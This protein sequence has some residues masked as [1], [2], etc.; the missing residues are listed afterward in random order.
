MKNIY[1]LSFI[2]TVAFCFLVSISLFAQNTG[3]LRGTVSDSLTGEAL[4]FSNV[5]LEGTNYG[6]SADLNGNFIISGIPAGKNYILIVSYLS[7]TKKKI[8]VSVAK[9]Q[10]LQMRVDLSPTTVMLQ[11]V[12]KIGEK[13]ARPNETDL[14]L[15][16]LNIRDIE[17]LPKGIE[18]DILRSLQS[19]PGVQSTGDVSARYYVRGGSSNENLVLL[20]GVSVYNPFHALGLFSIIDPEMINAVEFYRGGFSSEFGGRLSSVLNLV[21]KDGNKNRYSGNAN[22]SFLT[23]KAAFEGPLPGGSFML[24]G[25]KSLFSKTLRRFINYKDAPFDF[26]DLSFKANFNNSSDKSLTKVSVHGFNSLDNLT[27]EDPTKANYRWVN[28]IFGASWFQ[29]WENV[30]IFSESKLSYSGFEGKIDPNLSSAKRRYNKVDDITFQTDFTNIYDTRDELKVGYKFKSVKTEL[31]F[32]SLQGTPTSSSQSGL[33]LSLYGKYRF[34]R[35]DD[36]GVDIGTRVNVLSLTNKHAAIFEPRIN[37]TYN[38]LPGFAVK[39]AWGIYTQ[40][41]ITLI[42]ENEVISLFE[43]WLISPDYLE[44]PQASHYIAG[45]SWSR[46]EYLS[47]DIEGYYKKLMK[48]AELNNLKADAL[49]PD[50]VQGEG[51]SYGFELLL[52]YLHP[53]VQFTGSYSLSWSYK[54]VNGWV[55]YP[56]YDTRHS[57]N[58][59]MGFNF[60]AGWSASATWI[61]GSGLPF[62]QIAG[63]YDKLY[64][65]DLFSWNGASE[66]YQPFTILGDR[67]LGRLPNYHRLDLSISKDIKLSFLNASVSFNVL[68]AYDRKNIFYFDRKTGE[69]VNMLPVLPS[70]TLRIEI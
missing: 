30:P 43:P 29:A 12:E 11:T 49:D 47:V 16:K 37:I 46:Y 63:F 33:H 27:N 10:L 57:V 55:S 58:L 34:L 4:P 41:L 67:N 8:K 20:N 56:R 2:K 50:F 3:A 40:E 38:L 61:F 22:I 51:E 28:N 36:L 1:N 52:K 25:R 59:N 26:H 13:Q 65:D 68:N 18:T 23:G 69:R 39:A 48:T 62:T 15:Q 45:I 54:T 17:L 53:V 6:A 14:G 5:I 70:A 42:N 31:N 44:T 35:W 19:L 24:T 7:Y 32:E 66:N 9:G 64:F 60:G 21:T